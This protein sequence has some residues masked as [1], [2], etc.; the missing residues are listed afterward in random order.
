MTNGCFDIL[1]EGH[2][3]YLQQARA[4]GDRLVVAV[5]DDDSVRRLKGADRPINGVESRMAVLA[6]L[7]SVDWV[8]AFSED[9]PRDLVCR[10]RPDLLVKGGDY[11]PDAI[12]GAECVRAAGGE[13][14]VLPFLPGRST[15]RIIGAILQ[16][17]ENRGPHDA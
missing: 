13:V 14:R 11:A 8:C 10:V 16:Q 2:V 3:A 7:A 4:L 15:S 1:H 5:N 9:T 6:G 17:G 12:A